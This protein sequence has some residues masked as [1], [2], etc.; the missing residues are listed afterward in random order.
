[1][2]VPVRIK[3]FSGESGDG[4]PKSQPKDGYFADDGER[5]GKTWS[6]FVRG[7]FLEEVNGQSSFVRAVSI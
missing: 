6:I 2:P 4:Q 7:R 5:R 3:N 1:M